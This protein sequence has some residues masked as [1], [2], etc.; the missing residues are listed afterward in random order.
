MTRD[1]LTNQYYILR[2]RGSI[3]LKL[4][5][6]VKSHK[7]PGREEKYEYIL[8][9]LTDIIKSYDVFTVETNLPGEEKLSVK[10]QN[11]IVDL[12]NNIIN[13]LLGYAD[14]MYIIRLRNLIWFFRKDTEEL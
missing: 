9:T 12:G 2:N 8:N 6:N 11:Y 14:S 7:G 10:L 1:L 5:N 13:E 4:V 3:L